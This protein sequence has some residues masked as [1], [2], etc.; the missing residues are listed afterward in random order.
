VT[1]GVGAAV[2]VPLDE[3]QLADWP[4]EFRPGIGRVLLM[5]HGT[6]GNEQEILALSEALDPTAAVLAPRG[7]ATEG[8]MNRW[9]R[10]FAEGSFDVDDVIV[11]A[12]E[13][14]SFVSWARAHYGIENLPITA[15]GFSNGANIAL[16]VAQ[17]HPDVLRAVIAF[18]G[19]YPFA[20]RV[21]EGTLEG[22][23]LLVSN[24]ES[25]A[26]APLPSVE[27]LVAELTRKG[28]DVTVTRRPG[29]H[30]IDPAEL[31]A[32]V[33]WLAARP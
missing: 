4:H 17:L 15:V 20:D 21:V 22:S 8:G 30:G 13:L 2:G 12:A 28:A 16:A 32:A 25:D 18:S 19:M 6:G 7:R 9:F 11:R 5:L 33:T 23:H 27:R 10:R 26:M 31:A 29:S 14:A 1:D 24:G 3:Q